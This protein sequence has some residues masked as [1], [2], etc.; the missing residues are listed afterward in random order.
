MATWVPDHKLITARDQFIWMFPNCGNPQKVQRYPL[1][2]AESLRAMAAKN[3]ELFIPAHGLPI[4]G[5]DR[6]V[7][8]LETVA[9]TLETL[10]V[11][12]ID[13]MNT[14][15][16][17]DEI[18]H[19]VSVP[20]ETLVI[21]YLR[22]LYDEPEFV[23]RNLWRLYGGWWDGNPARLKPAPD[24]AV[25]AELVA[26]LGGPEQLID[27]ALT[28]S[29]AGDFRLACQLIEFAADGEP[30]SVAVHQA[31]AAIYDR[32]R[33]SERSLMA[34]GIYLSAVADSTETVTGEV[35]EFTMKVALS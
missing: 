17:L 2:W 31:R 12:V 30:E 29:E 1:E 27:R 15:A 28:L 13:A 35:P 32:R 16:K 19:S 26:L 3:P 11:Q 21:P 24:A 25:G 34:K 22:P 7:T 10:A 14:G 5:R 20:E 18:I 8:C 4:A 33:K 23:I 6:I 9:S